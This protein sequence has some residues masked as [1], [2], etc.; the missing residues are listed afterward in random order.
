MTMK[1]ADPFPT[2]AMAVIAASDA[3]MLLLDGD[4]A[5]L[6]VSDSFSATFG[7][8][9]AVLI[10]MNIYDLHNR[11]WDKPRLRAL[12][13]ATMSGLAAVD[14]YELTLTLPEL[15]KRRLMVK[16]QKLRY[17][18][19]DEQRLLI[20]V[21]DVTEARLSAQLAEDRLREKAL[22]LNEVQHRVANSLQIIASIL[23]QSARQVQSEEARGHLTDAHQRVMSIAM[24]QRHLAETGQSET[25]LAP[26]LTQLCDSIGASMIY[27]PDQLK[28]SSQ[29]D[30]HRVA[31]DVSVSLGL[32]VTELV[33]NALKHAF[34][35][36][37]P[38]QVT[39]SYTK[40]GADWTLSVSDNGIGMPSAPHEAT[41]GLGTSIVHALAK[42]LQAEIVV[43]NCAPGTRVS[44]I[45]TC[46][47][48]PDR[49][50]T[51]AAV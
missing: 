22:L 4:M 8:T 40:R 10:G 34:P 1:I 45:H 41:A 2:L 30:A 26:Y 36:K 18:S 42:Q 20:V 49:S 31:A 9:P 19:Q 50:G 32:V 14:R 46:A 35:D 6:A 48:D 15:G 21:A 25:E 39:V 38:G 37:Q 33:I 24:L 51:Q 3:L 29:V 11:K 47:A 13:N 27:D 43:S 28:L 23:I 16:A 7:S 12:L 44:L 5:I 17:G